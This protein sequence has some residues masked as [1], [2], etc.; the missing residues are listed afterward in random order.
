MNGE[1]WE[2]WS[3]RTGNLMEEFATEAD[4]LAAVAQIVTAFGPAY[5]DAVVLLRGPISGDGDMQSV[6]AGADLV[7]LARPFLAQADRS[8]PASLHSTDD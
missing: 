3:T 5:L 7:T 8:A 6:A 1:I 4:A 2:M